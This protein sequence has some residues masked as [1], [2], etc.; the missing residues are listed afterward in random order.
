MTSSLF[1]VTCDMCHKV[2]DMQQEAAMSDKDLTRLSE[3]GMFVGIF[4]VLVLLVA[5]P[6]VF[7]L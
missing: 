6:V 7:F 5:I 4:S 3:I 1:V 2:K